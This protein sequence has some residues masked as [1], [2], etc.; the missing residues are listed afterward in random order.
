MAA[1]FEPDDAEYLVEMERAAWAQHDTAFYVDLGTADADHEAAYAEGCAKW[2]GWNFR[3]LTGDP[4]L[5]RD[6]LSGNWDPE[7]FLI[8]RPGE[9]IA[10]SPDDRIVR[11]E[12]A[13]G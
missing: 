13:D 4:T 9:R 3:R 7:R 5:F 11:A 2:L 1:Q 6:L 12:P 10:H 8:V